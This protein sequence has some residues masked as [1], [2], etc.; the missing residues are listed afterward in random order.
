MIKNIYSFSEINIIIPYSLIVFDIDETILRFPTIENDWWS[1]KYKE[2]LPIYKERTHYQIEKL[3]IK[4]ISQAEPVLLD[5]INFK[6]FINKL[7]QNNCEIIFLTARNLNL[8][9]LTIEHLNKCNIVIDSSKIYYNKDKGYELKNIILNNYPYVKNIIFID[10]L[11]ENLS[12]VKSTFSSLELLNYN[13][14]LYQ[15]KHI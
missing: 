3:W 5:P 1:K 12:N 2:L 7:K 11:Y 4:Y 10:D 14:D 8:S 15:I 9:K 13:I 6:F